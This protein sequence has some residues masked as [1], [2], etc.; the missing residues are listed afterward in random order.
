M[1]LSTRHAPTRG[2]VPRLL[3]HPGR[4]HSAW[5]RWSAEKFEAGD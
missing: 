1:E 4:S 5:R 2:H 3:D